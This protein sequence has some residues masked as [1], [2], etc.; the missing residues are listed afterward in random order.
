M[1][2][3]YGAKLFES[4]S[5]NVAVSHLLGS[6]V[7][8]GSLICIA[9]AGKRSSS[10]LNVASAFDTK[11][12]TWDW[13]FYG[14]TYRAVGV[15]WCRTSVAMTTSDRI[16]IQWNGTPTYAWK[17]AHSFIG[18]SGTPDE[19][20]FASGTGSTASVT[21]DVTGSDWLTFA[22]IMLPD[23]FGVTATPLNSALS[24]DDNGHASS[25]PWAECFSR[26][27]TVGSTHTIGASFVAS[28]QYAIAGVSFPAE[29]LS[30]PAVA[31]SFAFLP[32]V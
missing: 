9:L 24:R 1:A 13:K 28:L 7:A 23:D 25:S 32:G 11:G 10:L 8:A 19:E 26:N 18:A 3:T 20:T 15:A 21:L 2:I 6:S 17:S 12:N 14:S 22:A 16:T 4:E 27:G 29:A 5:T 31:R 30:A